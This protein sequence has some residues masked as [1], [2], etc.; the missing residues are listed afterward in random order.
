MMLVIDQSCERAGLALMRGDTVCARQS[1]PAVRRGADPLFDHWRELL[2]SSG[3]DPESIQHVV[4]G[5]GPGNYT[6]LRVSLAA[7]RLWALPANLPVYGVGSSLAIAVAAA[8]IATAAN[9]A[10]SGRPVVV[11]GDARRDTV[12]RIR[13]PPPVGLHSEEQA[14]AIV[15]RAEW[16]RQIERDAVIWTSA[17]WGRLAVP[18]EAA[19]LP[20]CLIPENV[21]PAPEILGR[22]ARHRRHH[23]ALHPPLRPVYLQPPVRQ[24]RDAGWNAS[25]SRRTLT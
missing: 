20:G 13:Y 15:S 1:W 12:W 7:A 18:E 6:G 16:R 3:T 17:D 4:V 22:I 25:P 5:L 21:V 24:P 11:V 10:A 2:A 23:H 9:D 8:A 14:P 19:R